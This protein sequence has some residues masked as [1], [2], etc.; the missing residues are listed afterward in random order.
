ME[1]LKNRDHEERP[2]GSFDRFTLNEPSTVKLLTLK[3]GEEISLQKHQ[4]RGEFWRVVRGSGTAT[5]GGRMLL[6]GEGSEFSI[7]PGVE[8]RLKAG[9]EGLGWLEIALGKFSENDEAR[10]ADDYQR[11]SPQ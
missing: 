2:W 5:I 3:P 10:L 8:H 11:G 7:A 6:A 1:L 4:K 9:P